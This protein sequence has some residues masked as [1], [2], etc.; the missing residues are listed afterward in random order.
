VIA[1]KIKK[2]LMF[3]AGGFLASEILKRQPSIIA[4]S[5]KECDITD[6]KKVLD[7]VNKYKPS[8]IINCA[9][10]TDL[11]YCEKHPLKA[12]EVNVIG[13]RNISEA[14]KKNK[15]FMVH[16]SSDYALNP[17][18]EY[19]WTKFASEFLVHGL[20][21]RTNLY[22]E[23][24]WL[25]KALKNRQKVNLLTNIKFNPISVPSLL[26]YMNDLV[27]KKYFGL[28]NVGVKDILSYYDLGIALC[29]IF[30][31]D[32]K[33]IKKVTSI[34]VGYDYPEDTYLNLDC[35]R[36]LGFKILSVKEDMELLKNEIRK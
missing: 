32:K 29:D 17:M 20:V 28:V 23:S 7:V 18:N 13:V 36:R 35:L 9:A 8:I 22:N 31:F 21:I 5:Q 1:L 2:T 16:F 25:F 26:N 3:G 15:S 33:L 4:L 30:G 12:W 19:G 11:N 27:K 6:R 10:I 34:E 24:H 14:T